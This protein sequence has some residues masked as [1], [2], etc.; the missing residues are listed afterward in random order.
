MS[1]QIIVTGTKWGYYSKFK[2]PRDRVLFLI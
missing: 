1:I 2:T